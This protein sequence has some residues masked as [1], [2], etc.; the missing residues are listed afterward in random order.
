MAAAHGRVFMAI[1]TQEVIEMNSAKTTVFDTIVVGSGPGGGTVAR[2]LSRR[3]QRV[4]ILEWGRN[5]PVKGTAT[6]AIRDLLS[7]GRGLLVT[8]G[9]L[10]LGR[11]ITT[12]GSSI[13][14]YASAIDP[15]LEMFREH[16]IELEDELEELKAELP[17]GPLAE[18]LIG[19]FASRIMASARDLGLD[20]KPLP[21]LVFQEECRTDCDK[22][23]LGCPH[24]AKWTSRFFVEEAVQH[25]AQLVNTAKVER[26]LTE[27]GSAVGVE[28]KV[29]GKWVRFLA[30]RVVV[31]AG[32]I[33]TPVILTASGI[34]GAGQDFFFDP[35]VA[36]MGSVDDVKGGREFPMAAGIQMEEEGFVLTD[37]PWPRWMFQLFAAEVFRFDRL[38]SHGR[39][40]PIMVKIRD[41]LGGRLTARGGV[42]KPLSHIDRQRLKN[43][44]ELAKKILRN[45]GA[46]RIFTT[47]RMATHPGGSAKVGDVVDSDLKTEIDNLY[48]CDCS[49][50]PEA[51]GLPPTLTIL[52]LAKRLSKHIVREAAAA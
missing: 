50:I 10:A 24:G 47:W 42:R 14:Y 34:E 1:A 51:W 5:D 12:G 20:W 32:G 2:E 41:E 25:G 17:Y 16:G 23:T 29:N 26:V 43:G 37:L 45:A 39:T 31:S 21:K 11:G 44:A 46:K 18:K 4:L 7:P 13:F 33:G 8:P 40:L 28:A 6:Q 22:C 35:L 27:N 19:P 3:G 9:L 52:A 15:P 49:V 30:S 36:V 48:V 38:L